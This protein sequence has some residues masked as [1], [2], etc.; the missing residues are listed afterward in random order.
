M[1]INSCHIA[2]LLRVLTI[3]I[4]VGCSGDS[5]PA[6]DAASPTGAE[7]IEP[8]TAKATSCG[9]SA[10]QA[11]SA[12]QPICAENPDDAQLACLQ[13]I[14]CASLEPGAPLPCG[15]GGPSTGCDPA[16]PPSCDGDVVV[17]CTIVA[18]TPTEVRESCSATEL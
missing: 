8:C 4:V 11:A 2:H 16:D 17:S 5:S 14:P 12:C 13:S 10:A 9:A 18:G 1:D 3:T 6:S 15:L 7:C